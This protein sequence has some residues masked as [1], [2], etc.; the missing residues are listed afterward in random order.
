MITVLQSTAQIHLD[1]IGIMEVKATCPDRMALHSSDEVNCSVAV[2]RELKLDKTRIYKILVGLNKS[3][4][5]NLPLQIRAKVPP[6][7]PLIQGK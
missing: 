4:V 7:L 2:V 5:E 1:L 6:N 3:I